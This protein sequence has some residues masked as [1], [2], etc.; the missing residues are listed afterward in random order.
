MKSWSLISFSLGTPGKDSVR[1]GPAPCM[2]RPRHYGGGWSRAG[3]GFGSWQYPAVPGGQGPVSG[4]SPGLP[5]SGCYAT[6]LTRS[7]EGQGLQL[8]WE[9]VIIGFLL[10]GPAAGRVGR[11]VGPAN[12]ALTVGGMPCAEPLTASAQPRMQQPRQKLSCHEPAPHCTCPWATRGGL[13]SRPQLC[14]T[15][16]QLQHS[17]T[18]QSKSHLNRR[19]LPEC[20]STHVLHIHTHTLH[21]H[22]TALSLSP[23]GTLAS[24]P[25]HGSPESLIL[26]FCPQGLPRTWGRC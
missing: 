4:M 16:T 13:G 26:P 21:S 6:Q 11:V 22:Q 18:L 1:K 14:T 2:V 10:A 5:V 24:D 25:R 7:D 17:H 19:L 3:S 20:R 9:A 23:R 15:D 8:Q 12:Q